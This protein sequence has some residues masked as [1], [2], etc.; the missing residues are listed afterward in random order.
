MRMKNPSR[1]VKRYRDALG[2]W[3]NVPAETC[4]AVLDATGG[5]ESAAADPVLVV[6][7]GQRK[8]LRRPAEI[9]LEG[10]TH[11]RADIGLPR[12]LPLGYHD[13]RYLDAETVTRLI[14]TPSSCYLPADLRIWGLSAQLYALRSS[15]SWG[16]GD[17]ANLRRL[18]HWSAKELS[19]RVLLVNPLQAALPILPQQPSP[20]FPSTRRY[21]NLLYLRIEEIPGASEASLDLQ[22]YAAAGKALNHERRIDRDA[23]F[24]LKMAA[25]EVLWPRIR[26]TSR[27]DQFCAEQGQPLAQFAT[28]CALAEQYRSGWRQ[29]PSEYRHPDSLAVGRFA[30]ERSERVRFYQWVQWLL[31]EQL[32]RAADEIALMQDLPIGVD[33]NGADAW[34][35]QDLFAGGVTVGCPPDEYNT[36]GQDWGLPPLIPWKLRQAGYEPFIQTI[37]GTLRHARGLRIDHVMGLFRLFWI[38]ES[39]GP[40]AGAYVRY[41]ADELLGILALESERAKAYIVGEDLG[42]VDEKAR[43]QLAD[44]GV[45]SYRVLWFETAPPSGY[46]QRALA[47]VTTHDLPTVAG[48]WTG[49]D[50]RVQRELELKPN[51]EGLQEIRRRLAAM[52]GLS[53]SSPIEDVIV[54]SYRLLAEAPC[55]ILSATVDDALAVEERPN[56]PGTTIER[57]PDW[58][59]ALP[60]SQEQLETGRLVHAIAGALNARIHGGASSDASSAGKAIEEAPSGG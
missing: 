33:P 41:D 11:V 34:A 17:L 9:T 14:V 18:A 31:D 56:M 52:A 6:R 42:T 22:S 36:Q 1:I 51:E 29:W 54:R 23:I 53:E 5:A 24:N 10:G 45:L 15:H 58:S 19:A 2:R 21:R 50:L 13:L 48:L 20:Y 32:G 16:M 27:F 12:D 39:V 4:R 35:W 7:Q 26:D 38:P 46:P 43:Q 8:R 47:A 25:L 28:F 57:W 60:Q 49:S 3:R 59:L 44:R 37:R 30:A 55:A 40:A